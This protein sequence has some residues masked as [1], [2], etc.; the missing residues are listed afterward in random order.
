MIKYVK[1]HYRTHIMYVLLLNKSAKVV[2]LSVYSEA[3]YVLQKCHQEMECQD[4]ICK[5]LLYITFAYMLLTPR[6]VLS[7]GY[8]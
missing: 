3:Y 5:I 8:I 6:P 4:L 7:S 1:P 2:L